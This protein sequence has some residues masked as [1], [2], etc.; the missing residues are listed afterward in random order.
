MSDEVP[1]TVEKGIKSWI[2]AV[3]FTAVLIGGELMREDYAKRGTAFW[4]GTFLVV[5]GLPLYLS[6][7]WWKLAQEKLDRR[8]LNALKAVSER[9]PWWARSI[10]TV[11]LALILAQFVP[12]L[13]SRF[14]STPN[15]PTMLCTDG[16]CTPP[17]LKPSPTYLR[18]VAIGAGPSQEL[19]LQGVST[20]TTDR[21]RVFVD[22]SQYRS[23]W[24]P[25]VRAYIGEIKE[26]VKG[27]SERIQLTNVAKMPNGGNNELW[28]GKPE[29]YHY[30]V[31]PDYSGVFPVDLV[32]ARVVVVGPV[33]EEQHHYFLLIHSADAKQYK[34]QTLKDYEL[35]D[36]ITQW[37]AEK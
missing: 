35:G 8:A 6:A 7:A 23:G 25:K 18:D 2:G 10:L 16:P 36:W 9:T 19:M 1:D 37:E 12:N 32:R 29:E 15:A 24:M 27:Q 14:W 20:V 5:I 21:L 22:Y 3:A 28:W 30:V 17:Q 26:P 13:W 4:V 34:L 11:L 33:G 31:Y